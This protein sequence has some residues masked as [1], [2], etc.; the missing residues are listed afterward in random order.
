MKSKSKKKEKKP[1]VQQEKTLPFEK[2]NYLWFFVGLLVLTIGFVFLSIGPWDS[3]WSRTLAPIIL[4][5]GYLVIIPWSI[6]Y[7]KKGKHSAQKTSN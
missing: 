2:G 1:V 6:M 4:V 7:H 3:F 5:I